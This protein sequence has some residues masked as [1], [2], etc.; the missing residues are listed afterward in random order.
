M[1]ILI[2]IFILKWTVCVNIVEVWLCCRC[3]VCVCVFI[4]S[5]LVLPMFKLELFR[6]QKCCFV[7]ENNKKHILGVPKIEKPVFGPLDFSI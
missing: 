1:R 4:W 2:C 3:W 5:F 7:L 6:F